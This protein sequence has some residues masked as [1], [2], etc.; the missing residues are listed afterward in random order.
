M[1]TTDRK[2]V[3]LLENGFCEKEYIE[4]Q[5]ILTDMSISSRIISSGDGMLTA[6]NKLD[7]PQDS[8]WGQKYAS[9]YKLGGIASNQFD[10]L[11]IPGGRRSAEK[12]KLNKDVKSFISGFMA[13]GKPVLIFN[14]AHDVLVYLGLLQTYHIANYAPDIKS[15]ADARIAGCHDRD[16]VKS[17]NLISLAGY[18]HD[19][20]ILQAYITA[21]L[22]GDL[23][24]FNSPPAS[25]DG[26]NKAA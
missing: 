25:M 8:Y 17:K 22:D 11:V 20:Q 1:I 5:P 21:I 10:I 4:L 19:P 16:V 12:L 26:T 3:F 14:L 9:D 13:S 23:S 24:D 18:D 6:W 2:A 7:Q 15:T